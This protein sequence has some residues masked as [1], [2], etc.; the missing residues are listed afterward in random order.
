MMRINKTMPGD[1]NKYPYSSY[2]PPKMA[3]NP[4]NALYLCFLPSF[5]SVAIKLSPNVYLLLLEHANIMRIHKLM[6]G[7]NIIIQ[8]SSYGPKKMAINT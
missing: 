2:G 1:K 5:S 3:I 6:P 8:N 7:E 4:Q